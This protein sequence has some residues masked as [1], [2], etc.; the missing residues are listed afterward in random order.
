MNIFVANLNFKLQEDE[1]LDLFENF[2]EVTSAKIIID[3][4]TGRSKGFG[5]VEMDNDDEANSAIADLNGQEVH[6]REMVV[7]QAEE[8]P[9][10]ERRF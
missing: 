1:L 7:K 2:G 10:R 4:E 3:R 8:R 6:G 5:F 9:R